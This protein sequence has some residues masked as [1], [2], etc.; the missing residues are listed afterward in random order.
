MPMTREDPVNNLTLA[1]DFAPLSTPVLCDA[2]LRHGQTLRIAPSGIRSLP[3]GSRI[4]GRALPARHAGSVDV[5]LEAIETGQAGDVLVIDD[6]GETAVACIGDL[7]ALECQA[8]GLAGMVVWGAH[9]DTR[10]LRQIE[11]PVFSYGATP[12]GPRQAAERPA[13]ALVSA[14]FGSFTVGREDVVFAD[15]DGVLF[16]P[17]A[18]LE[19]VVATARTIW[20]TERRQA[21][22]VRAGNNLRAQLGFAEFLRRRGGNSSYTFRDH[23]RD[24]GGEIEE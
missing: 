11:L 1:D 9:R 16:L 2:A 4:A 24:R 12:P 14:R 23:L 19:E 21:E 20:A 22:A 18:G 5:F 17:A 3:P 13:E 7:V 15:D 6:G 8:A 10:D